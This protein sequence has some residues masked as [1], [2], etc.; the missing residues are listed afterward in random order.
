[1]AK[2][3]GVEKS[4]ALG[5]RDKICMGRNSKRTPGLLAHVI[6]KYVTM[7]YQYIPG[8]P[9]LAILMLAALVAL[10][11][12]RKVDQL[13]AVHQNWRYWKLVVTDNVA[14]GTI[15]VLLIILYLRKGRPNPIYLMQISC[16]RPPGILRAPHSTFL[17]HSKISKIF[18]EESLEFQRK[19]LERC[20]LGQHT[21]FPM[22]FRYLPPKPSM[23]GAREEAEL[24]LFSCMDELLVKSKIDPK[25]IGVVVVNCSTFNPTPSLSSMIV[26]KYK[27]RSNVKTF[28]L[29]GMGCSAGVIALDVAKDALLV[30][31]NTY[32]VVFSTENITQNWYWG[33]N[34]PML[35]SNCLFRVGGSAILLSNK[36]SDKRR[37]RYRLNHLVRTHKGADDAAYH[38]A[39]QE[40]DGE[41]NVGVFLSKDIMKIASETL[42]LNMTALGPLVLPCTEQLRF[43]W[44]LISREIFKSEAPT[45]IPNF[46]RAF[47]HFCIHSGGRAVIAAVEEGLRLSSIDVEPTKMAL[48]RFGNTSASTTWYQFQYLEGKG[49]INKGDRI[50][51][52]AFGSGFKCNSAVWIALRPVEPLEPLNAWSDCIMEYPVAMPDCVDI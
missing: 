23:T 10:L 36:P 32:A 12:S 8:G 7:G 39:Y 25:D 11:S 49:R 31:N 21:A 14:T 40:E 44:N 51:Q 4:P 24:V 27:L 1:M 30:H 43:L 42:K 20:G 5:A 29:G 17:E 19:I 28:N 16:F 50:W 2:A 6:V 38:A 3:G 34:K 9:D 46:K 45:Y 15:V 13:L 22:S 52:I 33:N 18:N 41:G 37:A 48:H 47:E 26:N 35:V